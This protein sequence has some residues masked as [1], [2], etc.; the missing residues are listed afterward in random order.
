MT[1]RMLKVVVLTALAPAWAACGPS[2]TAQDDGGGQGRG[3]A[4]PVYLRYENFVT[5]ISPRGDRVAS[6]NVVT[7]KTSVVRLAGPQDAPLTVFP[8]GGPGVVALSVQGPRVTRIAAS[9]AV[10]GTLIAQDLREPAEGNVTP[11]VAADVAAYVVGRYAYAFSS[12]SNRW[13]VVEL[14]AGHDEFPTVGNGQATVSA[15]GH[16]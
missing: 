16:V 3:S 13:D 10:D 2:A 9:D 12:R 5:A 15:P 1:T 7:G 8:I 11:I 14:A 6:V 4:G